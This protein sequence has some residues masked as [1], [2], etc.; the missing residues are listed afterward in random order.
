M[1]KLCYWGVTIA[2]L[3]ICE[4]TVTSAQIGNQRDAGDTLGAE[5]DS[6]GSGNN[7]GV[8]DQ[9]GGGDN[10]SKTGNQNN[11][12]VAGNTNCSCMRELNALKR[13]LREEMNQRLALKAALDTYVSELYDLRNQVTANYSKTPAPNAIAASPSASSV[14]FSAKLSYNR[15]LKPLDTVV[16]DTVLTNEGDA[17][18][19]DSGKFTATGAGTYLFHA[20]IL[21]GYNTKVETAIIV[22]DKEVA[23]IYSGA[24]DAHGSGSNMAVVDLRSGDLVW[25]RLLYQGGNHVHGYYSTFTGALLQPA[26]A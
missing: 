24:H 16:F 2:T 20:T 18:S 3:V 4:A 8:A 10:S 9:E 21:S 6:T 26:H 11:P 12:W 15:E 19:P 14:A 13:D 25:V 22:N 5:R 1:F 23:R 17:Y 7:V